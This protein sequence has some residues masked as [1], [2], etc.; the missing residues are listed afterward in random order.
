MSWCADHSFTANGEHNVQVRL[1]FQRVETDRERNEL[2]SAPSPGG[3]R[4]GALLDLV[5]DRELLFL[6]VFFP[7]G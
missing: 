3:I 5:M 2:G 4:R 1:A 6:A 7:D